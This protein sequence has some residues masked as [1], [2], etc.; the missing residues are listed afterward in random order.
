MSTIKHREIDIYSDRARGGY[1]A[2]YV[3]LS[4]VV[5]ELHIRYDND[6]EGMAW[7]FN[8]QPPRMPIFCPGKQ[9][10]IVNLYD[11]LNREGS[12]RI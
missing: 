1:E 6:F 7:V 2:Y 3:T 8:E 11:P 9:E 5:R 10:V 12:L 4:A